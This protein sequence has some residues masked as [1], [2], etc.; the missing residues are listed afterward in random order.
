M[1]IDITGLGHAIVDLQFKINEEFTPII[2][3]LGIDFGSMTLKDAEGQRELIEALSTHNLESITACG[4]SATNSIIAA[5]SFG[6]K[7]HYS[8][9]V[10]NDDLGNFYI[11]NL[12]ENEITN[13]IL[14]KDNSEPTGQSIIMVTPDTER[15]M[16]TCLGVSESL[17]IK[18]IDISGIRNSKFLL[19]EGYLGTSDSAFKACIEA[20]KLA[21]EN[22][23]K[24]AFSLSDHNIV[25][26][27]YD[28]I[29][30]IIM[31]DIDIIF[32]NEKEAMAFTSSNSL[33]N[34]KKVISKRAA[35]I[36]ITKGE[37]GASVW[38]GKYFL[39]ID[40][41]KANAI[42][43]NGAGDM[44]AGAVLYSLSQELG[45]IESAKFGCY[46][47]SK[48]VEHFGPRLKKTDYL[49]LKESY[50]F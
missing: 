15:T 4:G 42:D 26:A 32:C 18:D 28:R 50:S 12:E 24:I 47:A 9:K 19:I 44:F 46:A 45:P 17:S 5:S 36:F 29:Q 3:N 10:S 34:A 31:S 27:F 35:N 39:E 48:Q 30:E 43:S 38:D 14:C 6:A 22:D 21:K 16:C 20:I 37:N 8:C 7:C 40:A 11:T 33:D 23:T 1:S 41:V 13:N 49:K 25:S 2:K